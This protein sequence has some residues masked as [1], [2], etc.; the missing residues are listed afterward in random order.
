MSKIKFKVAGIAFQRK[1][2]SIISHNYVGYTYA[3]SKKQAVLQLERREGVTLRD[4]IVDELSAT[5]EPEFVQLSL[6]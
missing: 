4:V 6:F 3:Y 5:I 2:D 1:S